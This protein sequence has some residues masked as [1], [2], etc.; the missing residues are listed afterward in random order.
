MVRKVGAG[1]ASNTLFHYFQCETWVDHPFAVF[2]IP[3][4]SIAG[5]FLELS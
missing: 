1:V 2:D 5:V 4:R 3:Y